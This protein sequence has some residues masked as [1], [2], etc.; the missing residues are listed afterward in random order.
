MSVSPNKAN[1]PL[2]VDA[3]RVLPAPVAAQRLKSIAGR[4]T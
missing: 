1:P 2:V 4:H 3:D